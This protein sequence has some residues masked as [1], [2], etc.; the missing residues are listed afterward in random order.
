M[1]EDDEVIIGVYGD[2]ENPGNYPYFSSIGFIVW[3]RP[4]Y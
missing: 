2:K 3:K 4:K 1:L